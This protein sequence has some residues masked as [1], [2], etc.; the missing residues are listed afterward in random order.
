MDRGHDV[1]IA[2]PVPA[3]AFENGKTEVPI[4]PLPLLRG[5]DYPFETS[6]A[7]QKRN[8]AALQKVITE[9]RPEVIHVQ[10]LQHLGWETLSQL[11]ESGI[12]FV[13]SLHDYW[14]LCRNIQRMCGGSSI[15]C[16][17]KCSPVPAVE[18]LPHY[19]KTRKRRI[20]CTRLLN[21][22]AAPLVTPSHRTAEIYGESGVSIGRVVT[23]P[24]GINTANLQ[25]HPVV[26]RKNVPIRFG[27]LGSLSSAK[28]VDVLIRA[29]RNLSNLGASLHIYG[30]GHS[31][32]VETLQTLSI[33]ASVKFYGKYNHGD[34]TRILSNVDVV[35]MPS[36]W[37][38]TYGLVAQE[39]LAAHKVVI[40]SAIGGFRERF[41]Q[42]INGFLSAPGDPDAL[43]HTM[44]FVAEHY[45]EIRAKLNFEFFSQDIQV[46]GGKFETLYEWTIQNWSGLCAGT[47]LPIE[48][49]WQETGALISGY[50]NEDKASVLKKLKNEWKDQGSTVASAWNNANPSTDEEINAFYKTTDSYLYDLAIAHRSSERRKW[51]EA[52][53]ALL[54][55]N[56]VQTVLDY[57]G[58]CGDDSLMFARAGFDCSLY[59]LSP[60]NRGFAD[61]RAQQ[62][63]LKL[64]ILGEPSS[65]EAYDAIYCT[66]MLEH[67][68]EPYREIKKM[69]ELVRPGGVVILTHSFDLL[70]ESHP[71]HLE[72]HRGL[73]EGFVS[74]VEALGFV[75]DE[76]V[77]IPFNKFY[78]FRANGS[79]K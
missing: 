11:Q 31:E 59:D 57:G 18:F 43:A 2:S 30:S 63:G 29:F 64:N 34:L 23:Q 42:G 13:V 49:D 70:G 33:G 38:E 53:I 8:R 16:A 5:N 14:F 24:L 50:L 21:G 72:R 73:G 20:A 19:Y 27:Y 66:E 47:V 39:A 41:F 3:S 62:S 45:D 6:P 7:L 52:A 61:F 76:V 79:G 44:A 12:P 37:E 46:D 36:I 25:S 77:I 35:V 56:E 51:R 71:S 75:L 32:F 28:G 10:H 65:V 15:A 17:T 69:R 9:F 60:V 74:E 1:L 55:K 48:W 4:Q 58:G 54:A 22:I 78:V 40:A 68:P 26:A 67:V